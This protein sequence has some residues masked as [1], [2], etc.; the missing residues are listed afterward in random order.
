MKLM[1]RRVLIG[2]VCG[3]VSSPFLC[4]AVRD[5]GLGVVLGALLGIAQMFAFFDLG[6]GSAIDRA[7]TCA[8]LG[9]P[10]WLICQ[11]TTNR[12]A[13]N[14]ADDGSYPPAGSPALSDFGFL[15]GA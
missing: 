15:G 1:V 4:L 6:G 2:L 13:P 11:K 9:L 8:A 3:T 5:I 7:M 12:H 10:F 14:S